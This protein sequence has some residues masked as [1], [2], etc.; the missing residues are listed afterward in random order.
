MSTPLTVPARIK[1]GDVIGFVS[2]SAGPHPLAMHRIDQAKATL[3]KLGY[4][5]K[6]GTHALQSAGS[7]SGTIEERVA[8]L[9]DMFLD[10]DIKMIMCTIGGNDSNQLLKYLDY[11]LIKKNPKIFIG[12]SDIT[13]LHYAIQSQAGLAT[14]YG[15]CAMT[16]F[17][18]YP[19]ILEY[20]L[21]YFEQETGDS[22]DTQYDLPSSAQWTDEF[23]DWFKKQDLTRARTLKTNSGYEW[24]GEGTAEGPAL[25][26]AI[27][28]INHLAG[29]KYWLDAAGTI[30]FIDILKE[31]D[32]LNEDAVFSLLTD[33]DNIGVFEKINGLVISRPAGFS[34]EETLRLKVKIVSFFKNKKCPILFN[35]NIGHTD[36]IATIRYG[37]RVRLDSLRNTVTML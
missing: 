13:V 4:R 33:L 10:P 29:T 26:G 18:E 27:L 7:V 25:G 2:P 35:A 5:V 17:G 3:E 11:S 34:D 19:E 16:Q 12:Y 8:D 24:I 30:F 22:P 32:L 14:Y 20:S 6:Y 36:P 37:R 15:P 23:L 9:H 21:K 31:N 1:K 28:S